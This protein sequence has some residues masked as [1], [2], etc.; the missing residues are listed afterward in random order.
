MDAVAVS[1]SNGMAFRGLDRRDYIAMPFLF[2]IFQG[3]MP[4]A[5]YYAGSLLAGLITRYSGIIIC[6]ILSLIGGNMIRE[7]LRGDA[8]EVKDKGLTAGVLLLQAVATSIDA[9]AVGVG[10]CAVQ[11]EILP[12]AGVITAVTVVLVAF[13]LAVGRRFGDA[14][15]SR[16][17]L[18]GGLVLVIIGLKAL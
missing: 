18:A 3:L 5:G 16:A 1:M 2:G 10:F 13:A 6:A 12:A 7:G 15:G 8:A 14:F 11:T 9:F 17:E 4:L